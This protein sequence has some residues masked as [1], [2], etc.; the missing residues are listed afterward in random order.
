MADGLFVRSGLFYVLADVGLKPLEELFR[1]RVIAFLVG[2]GLLVWEAAPLLC[3]ICSREM[4]IVALIDDRGVVERILRHRG[5][6]KQGVRVRT[7]ADPP[8]EGII[9]PSLEDPFPDYDTE[10]VMTYAKS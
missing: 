2:K 7:G 1:A 3:P 9:E 6:W 5:L 8:P 4:R 10:P